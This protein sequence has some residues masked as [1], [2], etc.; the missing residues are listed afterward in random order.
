[1]RLCLQRVQPD[2]QPVQLRQLC[3]RA[4]IGRVWLSVLWDDLLRL[5]SF[6]PRC[7]GCTSPQ[8]FSCYGSSIVPNLSG[9]LGYLPTEVQN[10]IA[11]A[12][13]P[14][15][16]Q[17]VIGGPAAYGF[18]G[19]PYTST[20]L[21][22]RA[23]VTGATYP[24]I[25][26]FG[27]GAVGPGDPS[28]PPRSTEFDYGRGYP[29]VASSLPQGSDLGLLPV[30]T[31]LQD[32]SLRLQDCADPGSAAALRSCRTGAPLVTAARSR[33]SATPAVGDVAIPALQS[34]AAGLVAAQPA[35]PELCPHPLWRYLPWFPR[36]VLGG[37][38]AAAVLPA[39]EDGEP[40]DA[41]APSGASAA[42]VLSVLCGLA[43]WVWSFVRRRAQRLGWG[44][45]GD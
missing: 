33:T 39:G 28:Y 9:C 29:A 40:P 31:F 26:D 35:A 3:V 7:N 34:G 44:M 37:A 2:L 45:R 21:G 25:R 27:Y 17:P 8:V 32:P 24:V 20:S 16:T 15:W 14:L 1:M 19:S 36:A 11:S 12:I 42:A 38:A 10:V 30:Q 6:L 4:A 5:H 22:D 18:G 13:P 43:L 23:Y 41:G